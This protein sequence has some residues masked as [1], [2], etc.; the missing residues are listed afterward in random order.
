MHPETADFSI[1]A[2]G[3]RANGCVAGTA[4]RI[5][6]AIAYNSQSF[7]AAKGIRPASNGARETP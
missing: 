7:A 1:E 2:R 4:T 5:A 3:G 6:G